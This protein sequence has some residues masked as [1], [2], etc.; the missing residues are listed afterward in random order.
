MQCKY[1][2]IT[3]WIVLSIWLCCLGYQILKI[4]LKSQ[5]CSVNSF[6]LFSIE[7]LEKN[8][9]NAVIL[10]SFRYTNTIV[11]CQIGLCYNV[12]NA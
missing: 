11:D 6:S 9:E 4:A 7:K 8:A 2:I 1:K 3:F 12:I 10:Y 5:N